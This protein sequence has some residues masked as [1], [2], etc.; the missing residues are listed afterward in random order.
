MV[1]KDLPFLKEEAQN[2]TASHLTAHSPHLLKGL[3]EIFSHQGGIMSLI[4]KMF[5]RGK[6][7]KG[8]FPLIV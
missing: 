5:P 4:L 2:S 3:G 6:I 7:F 1:I 8:V